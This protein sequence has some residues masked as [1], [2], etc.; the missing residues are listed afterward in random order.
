[1]IRSES[2]RN[3][4]QQFPTSLFQHSGQKNG[5]DLNFKLDELN[6]SIQTNFEPFSF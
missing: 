2:I 3:R 5:L 6:I 1:M 4:I